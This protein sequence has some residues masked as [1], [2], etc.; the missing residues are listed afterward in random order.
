MKRQ[1][2]EKMG[3]IRKFILMLVLVALGFMGFVL[4]GIFGGN[5]LLITVTGACV[6]F[7]AFKDYDWFMN[8][9]RAAPLR[10]LFGRDGTRIL[11]IFFGIVMF[12]I[13]LTSL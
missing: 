12:F 2:S 1:M 8:S 13:G 6:V 11:Y 5:A 7:F 4:L 10:A 3:D 9:F